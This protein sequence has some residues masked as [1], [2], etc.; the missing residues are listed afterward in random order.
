[1]NEK[2]KGRQKAA[3]SITLT[4]DCTTPA[5]GDARKHFAGALL[6]HA[7]HIVAT[8]HQYGNKADIRGHLDNADDALSSLCWADDYVRHEERS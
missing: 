1:M 4:T 8:L 7:R 5:Q 3:P 6:R 2:T